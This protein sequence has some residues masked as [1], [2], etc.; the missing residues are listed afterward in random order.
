[1][2]LSKVTIENFR[3]FGEGEERF[4]L[5]LGKGL[6]A[7]VGENDSGKSAVIDAIR[8]ALGTTDQEWLRLDDS[9]FRDGDKARE[10]TIVCRFAGLTPADSGAF[11][12]YLTYDE[13][14][15]GERQPVLYVTYTAKDTG[16]QRYGRS[17]CRVQV[18]SGKNGDGPTL[19]DKARGMLNAT[20]L[21][22]LRDAEQA[23]SAGRGSRLSQVLQHTRQLEECGNP[24]KGSTLREAI[25]PSADAGDE[26]ER[27]RI[28][29]DELRRLSVLGIADLANDLLCHQEGIQDARKCVNTYLSELA[30]AGST[31]ATRIGVSGADA[32]DRVRLRQLLEK[33]DL[34][35]EDAGRPGLGS[36]NLLFI[37]CELLLLASEKV[38]SKLLLIEEP[39]AHLHP[40]RQLRVMQYLQHEACQRDLQVIVTTHSPNLASV[41][42][43][44]N[45]V[46]MQDGRPFPF[47]EE[48]TMLA[49]SDYR[50]LERFLDVTKANLFFARGVLIVEGDTENILLPVLASLLGHDL[51]E[52]GVS[53]VN[54]GGVGLRRYARIFQRRDVEEDGELGVRVACVTDMDVMP[55]CGP[56]IIGM[57]SGEEQWP[58]T[59]KRRWRAQQDYDGEA[60]A[61][62]R[63]ELEARA[64]GQCVR[65][66][67][68]DQWTLEYDLSLGRQDESGNYNGGLAEEVFVAA[69]LA[70]EDDALTQGKKKAAD[71]RKA[72]L[73]ALEDLDTSPRDG[74]TDMEVLAATVYA[75]FAKD[76]VSKPVA[77][78]YLAEMLQDRFN[79]GRLT[80][81]D[82][83]NRLPRYITDAIDYVTGNEPSQDEGGRDS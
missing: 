9:D 30:L 35:L 57:V 6:T 52:H 72:A 16:E 73:R 4:E 78:Q 10:I 61:R 37:A 29:P 59:S 40:Q 5:D 12:E 22:P 49:K 41:V 71:V 69:C 26:D 67:V 3:C 56:S 28:S 82:L 54:V 14:A 38:G 60:L 44:G 51:T 36:S 83:R 58:S 25:Q 8:F 68:S 43:L 21:R 45:M 13:S 62:R 2:Y 74:C 48:Q 79:D 18:R 39:E 33:L 64:S 47:A 50:F 75:R 15:S 66:F 55:D 76:S 19:D 53:V 81:E 20:Y 32:P 65:T 17:Y 11:L 42:K 46:M 24:Y 1:M 34:A 31:P 77:A 23:L 7:L 80:E 70:D 27:R 63:G